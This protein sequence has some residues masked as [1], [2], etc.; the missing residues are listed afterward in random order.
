LFARSSV[1]AMVCAAV[2]Y[3]IVLLWFMAQPRIAE[4]LQ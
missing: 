1:L 2:V 4:A 3:P